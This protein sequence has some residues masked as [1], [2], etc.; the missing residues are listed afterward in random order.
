MP[1]LTIKNI[2]EG[3]YRRLK[4]RAARNR[5]SMNNEVILCLEKELLAH[6]LDPKKFLAEVEA[7]RESLN[8]PPLT[9]E[10]L[11]WAKNKGRP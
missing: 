6:R 11:H 7:R 4:Q 5:R 1:S 8:I 2:P 3:L 9:D 10:F